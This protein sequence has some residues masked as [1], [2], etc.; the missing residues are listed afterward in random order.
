MIKW[1]DQGSLNIILFIRLAILLATRTIHLCV[2][3]KREKRK[4]LKSVT[5]V[6]ILHLRLPLQYGLKI[7]INADKFSN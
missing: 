6:A 1:D 2:Q 3:Y 7:D 5:I 4:C